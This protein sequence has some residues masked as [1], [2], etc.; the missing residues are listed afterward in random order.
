MLIFNRIILSNYLANDSIKEKYVNLGF[1][2]SIAWN[3]HKSQI[4]LEK[5][6]NLITYNRYLGKNLVKLAEK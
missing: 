5:P 1:A 4:S 2:A 3:F 6:F